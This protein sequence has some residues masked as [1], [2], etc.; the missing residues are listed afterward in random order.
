ML[1]PARR[2][3]SVTHVSS[4]LP[5]VWLRY[6]K[7][8]VAYA[9]IV[10]VLAFVPL[11]KIVDLW[12]FSIVVGLADVR[13]ATHV[14][15]LDLGAERG[16]VRRKLS[17]KLESLLKDPARLPK[18]VVIDVALAAR[19]GVPDGLRAALEHL[20]T[21][22]VE[23]FGAVVPARPG[24]SHT[25]VRLDSDLYA[26]GRAFS[27]IGHALLQPVSLIRGDRVVGYYPATQSTQ[28][29]SASIPVK[30]PAMALLVER[31][32]NPN[33]PN[34]SDDV[35]FFWTGPAAVPLP[36]SATEASHLY[37]TVVIGNKK[38]DSGLA[39]KY[40]RSDA[41]L[42]AWAIDDRLAAAKPF[43]NTAIMWLTTTLFSG[44]A[45][46]TFVA[47]WGRLKTRTFALT[48]TCA[49]APGISLVALVV[50][51]AVLFNLHVIYTELTLSVVGI[52][53]GAA[54]AF[55]WS[56]ETIRHERFLIALRSAANIVERFDVFISYARSAENA[57]W[58]EE[59]LVGPLRRATRADGQ[60]LR[61]FFDRDSI[62]TGMDWYKRL[63]DGIEGSRYFVPVY[64]KGY[65]NRYYCRDELALA[66]LRRRE[67]SDFIVP[68]S[69]TSKAP[70][71]LYRSIQYLDA[72]RTP[73][74]IDDILHTIAGRE[75]N[76][77]TFVS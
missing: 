27:G 62:G 5:Y 71:R 2:I 25:Q 42:L 54:V 37:K 10:L 38:T 53:T 70:P 55:V 74:F 59:H 69:R 77:T 31:A 13:G 57:A 39:A 32:L 76:A 45:V 58:V 73:S 18:I 1:L 28:L 4:G 9:F 16:Q 50:A 21:S 6:G 75:S 34:A 14:V 64:S 29:D 68:L 52:V 56:I 24:D 23:V 65:F 8:A 61:V 51:D 26:D 47:I 46:L 49:M 66:M 15:A 72:R 60:P 48:L 20:R 3:R 7:Y 35:A 17:A 40:G 30:V 36:S 11:W 41:E 19:H 44:I 22:N 67:L 43:F 12:L 63:V 33:V